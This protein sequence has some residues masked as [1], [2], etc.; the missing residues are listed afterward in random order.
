MNQISGMSRIDEELIHRRLEWPS[1][2]IRLIID[3]DAKNEI[4]DQYAITWALLSQD[5]FEILGILAEPYEFYSRRE[6]ILT[7]YEALKADPYAELEPLPKRFEASVRRMI[8]NGINP[9]HI[10]F[11]NSAEGMELS[12][13]EILKIVDL[14]AAD[15]ADRCYRGS[16]TYLTSYDE[17]VDSPAARFIVEQ[18]MNQSVTDDPIYIAAIGCITNVASA[19]LME[20]RIRERIVLTWTASYPS[21]WD[22]NNDF[23]LN[24]Y[25][26]PLASR[27]IFSCGVPHVFLPGFYISELLGI[28]LPD[29]ERWVTPHGRIGAYLHHLFT[30]NPVFT[31]RGI[32]T[33]DLF[34]RSWVFW[35]FI[36][37]AWLLNPEWVPTKI[38]PTPIL[39]EDLFFKRNP[40]AYPIREAIGLNRDEIYRDFFLKLARHAGNTPYGYQGA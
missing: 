1:G 30:N 12:Y 4:D 21:L 2:R 13:Q 17:P 8:E 9:Y 34:G 23:S 31:M 3:T 33:S 10:H 24:L 6:P 18:A 38:R 7:A 26:D 32:P 14:L 27:L 29:I 22:G 36:N 20:P 40:N 19:I 11:A 28:S 37:I 15:M 16:E 25:Q 35:D 39:T 5:K